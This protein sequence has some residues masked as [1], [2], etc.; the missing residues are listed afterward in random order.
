MLK[1]RES[2]THLHFN[3]PNISVY[4][5]FSLSSQNTVVNNAGIINDAWCPSE[6]YFISTSIIDHSWGQPIHL[7]LIHTNKRTESQSVPVLL[8]QTSERGRLH[9]YKASP[10][11]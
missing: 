7:S 1:A 9:G 2:T 6:S 11:M 10:I 8:T 5:L 3:I 4:G